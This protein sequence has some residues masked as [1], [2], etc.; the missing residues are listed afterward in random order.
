MAV[1]DKCPVCGHEYYTFVTPCGFWDRIM[2]ELYDSFGAVHEYEGRVY[3]HG[4]G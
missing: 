1:P 4:P 2:P 3:L